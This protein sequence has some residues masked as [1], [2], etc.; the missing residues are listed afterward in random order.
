M[1][2]SGAGSWHPLLVNC[3]LGVG[4]GR[5]LD[6]SQPR[7]PPASALSLWPRHPNLDSFEE[8]R[9]AAPCLSSP[10]ACT[11]SP[12]SPAPKSAL[13]RPPLSWPL[14]AGDPHGRSGLAVT[15]LLLPCCRLGTPQLLPG[16][17]TLTPG[18]YT[19]TLSFHSLPTRLAHPDH[20]L[21]CP[22]AVVDLSTLSLSLSHTHTHGHLLRSCHPLR[23]LPDYHF[24]LR[25]VSGHA[26]TLFCDACGCRC[27]LSPD[28]QCWSLG[29]SGGTQPCLECL[30]D[31]EQTLWGKAEQKGGNPLVN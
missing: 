24:A 11:S 27:D 16:A 3:M 14:S 31:K 4:A 22:H 13:A 9:P 29:W 17:P 18:C 7:R 1:L 20:C 6:P 21:G 10:P 23:P 25:H 8:A 28:H 19:T 26:I 15:L 30:Q 5:W 12:T 2:L